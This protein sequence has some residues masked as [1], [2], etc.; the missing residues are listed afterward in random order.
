MSNT[1]V[2][3]LRWHGKLPENYGKVFDEIA[4]LIRKEFIEFI[5]EV[6]SSMNNNLDW[7]VEGPASRNYFSSPLFHYCCSLVLLDKLASQNNL[8]RSILVDSKAFYALV[9]TWSSDNDLNLEVHLLSRIDESLI[10]KYFGSMLRPIKSSIKLLLLFLATRNNS[11]HAELTKITQPLILIDT[12]VRDGLE[13]KDQYYPGLWEN[14]DQSDKKRTYFVPEFERNSIFKIKKTINDLKLTKRNYIFKWG[15]L[16]FKD[17]LFA[18]SHYFRIRKLLVPKSNFRG[19][20]LQ[21]LIYEELFRGLNSGMAMKALLNYRFFQRLNQLGTKIETS[22]NWFENQGIDKGWNKGLHDYFPETKKKGYLGMI[23]SRHYLPMFP[24]QAE[25]R[26]RVLPDTL[27]VIGPGLEEDIKEFYPNL[28]V[29]TAPAFRFQGVYRNT[30]NL[31]ALSKLTVLVALYSVLEDAVSAVK[32]AL[33]T[34]LIL[35]NDISIKWIIKPHPSSHKNEILDAIDQ[36]IPDSWEW[37][38]N[39]F[40]EC[41]DEVNVLMG[42]ASTTCM[43][44]LAR[45]KFVI[46]IGNPHGITHNPI[47][48]SVQKHLWKECYYPSEAADTLIRHTYDFDEPSSNS[49]I[50]DAFFEPI[51]QKGVISLIS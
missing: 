28:L 15:F 39:D 10:K 21:E 38:E 44:A 48:F 46:I 40:H 35:E 5:S 13:L 24:T 49:S 17:F 43:E 33:D 4:Y 14:L 47:P 51:T 18:F 29:Q 41:L 31:N 23:I 7:W 30:S 2:L 3:D 19:F 20:S 42:N 6:S 27:F 37:L 26:A 11:G 8:S 16:N 9:K 36:H 25:R 32:F 22:I 34:H 50:R 1:D 12:F 45:E